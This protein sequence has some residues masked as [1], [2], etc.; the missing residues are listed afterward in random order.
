MREATE[1][2][3][4][5]SCGHESLKLIL[6]LGEQYVT[7]FVSSIGEQKSIPKVPL[8]LVLCEKCKLLQLKHN[9][10]PESM[11]GDQYW[12]KSGISSTIKN[13]LKDIVKSSEKIVNM[14]KNDVIVD[15]GCNDGTLLSFYE[16]GRGLNL[17]G[18]EPSKNVALEAKSKGFHV[19]NDFFN[20]GSFKGHFGKKK[21]K[22]IT[23]ISM[24]YDLEDPNAFLSDILEVLD[25]KGLFVIQQ[26][27]LVSM[28]EQ[29]AFDNICHEHREYYSIISLSDL[30]KRHG[31]EIFDICE[32]GI[33]GG[34]IRTYIRRKGNESLNGF[35][36]SENRIKKA[37]EK[38][39]RAGLESEKPYLEFASRI[40]G[41]KRRV[42]DF[43]NQ[44]KSKGKS[45]WIY[46]ASTRGNVILQYFGLH[47]GIIDCIADMNADKWGKKTVGSLIPINSPEEFRKA[48]S[49]YLLVNTWHFFDEIKDQERDYFGKGGKFIV[50]L[51]EFRVMEKN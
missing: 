43:L 1:I 7:N 24:F 34:S 30:L 16:K 10:P 28:L 32:S 26:N 11:W 41:I 27:Y 3:S 35:A 45:I 29:N 46:G 36:G 44:E 51:P 12:Y 50:A 8:E 21:A 40:R 49:D 38:E 25:E 9:A 33:N 42:M 13:D 14:E 5:R 23:A 18:F 19:I 31:L 6:S 2:K 20:A 47:P 48:N 22:V 15:I 39:K 17:I 4:C 37:L